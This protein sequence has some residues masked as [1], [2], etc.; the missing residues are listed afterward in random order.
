MAY[1]EDLL[2]QA[3]L[4]LNKEP[5]KPTQASLRRSVSTAYYALFHLLIQEASLNWSRMDTRDYLARAFDHKT[6]KEA[7]TRAE[8]A[9]YDPGIDNRIVA[10]L[11]SVAKAFRELQHQRHLADYSNATKWD[12]TKASANVRQAQTAFSDWK[13]IRN[14]RVAQRYLV[15][16]LCNYKEG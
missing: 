9:T 11:R 1:A 3:F 13:I 4:L 10:R 5:K 14:E 7:S 15:S 16:L 2:K 12:R 8:N 6:M